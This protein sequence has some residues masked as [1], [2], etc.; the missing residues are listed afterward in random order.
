MNHLHKQ[1]G[2][3][4]VVALLFL[5]LLSLLSVGLMIRGQVNKTTSAADLAATQAYYY[6]ETAIYYLSWALRND[7]ELDGIDTHSYLHSSNPVASVSA[8]DWSELTVN[9]FEP[10]PTTLAGTDGSVYYFDNRPLANRSYVFDAQNTQPNFATMVLPQHLSL[11]VSA[12][13]SIAVSPSLGTTSLTPT[14][15]AVIWLTAAD[16]ASAYDTAI[17]WNGSAYSAS[18]YGVTVYAIGY[19]DGVPR[20]MLRVIIGQLP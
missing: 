20:S 5:A 15:G 10:G 17:T 18:S 6:A 7:A 11:E 16:A 4:L 12:T 19:V 9:I 2:I 14:N 13:G 1:K 3:V 8:G